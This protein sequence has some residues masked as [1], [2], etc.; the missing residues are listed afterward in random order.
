MRIR[1]TRKTSYTALSNN[2]VRSTRLSLKAKG[3]LALML[4]LPDDWEYSVK[5]LA[6]LCLEGECAIESALSELKRER[7]LIVNKRLP[8]ETESKRFEY[9]YIVSDEPFESAD[10]DDEKPEN[11]EQEGDLQGV[12]NQGVENHPL[13]IYN[14]NKIKTNKR[15]NNKESSLHSLSAGAREGKPPFTP[16]TAD[17]VQEYCNERGNGI[18]A[19]EFIAHYESNGWMVGRTRMRNWKAAVRTWELKRRNTPQRY[20]DKQ[21]ESMDAIDR[22]IARYSAEEE[23]D[24]QSD[25][26][27]YCADNQSY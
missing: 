3:L 9:E 18:N 12:E 11:L 27:G 17:E 7:Y 15:K 25:G 4:S 2:C 13:A 8:N 19:E 24:E 14:N 1:L 16:P 23:A 10:P 20:V 22:I 5:G 21:Q 26:Q 6:A